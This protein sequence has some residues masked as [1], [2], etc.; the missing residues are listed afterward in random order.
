MSSPQLRRADRVMSEQRAW[1]MLERGFSGRLATVGVD[2]YPYCI[3]L[4]YIW[5]DGEVYV[6]TP[7]AL[8]GFDRERP[9]GVNAYSTLGGIVG[10][11]VRVTSPSR[12]SPRKVRVSIRCVIPP[13]RRLSSL[14]RRGSSPPNSTTISTLH[15]SPTRDKTGLTP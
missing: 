14:N 2:G 3:P 6:H 13:I 5:M 12:S 15:L 10:N 7:R 1:E 11:I 4:L 9:S 8:T